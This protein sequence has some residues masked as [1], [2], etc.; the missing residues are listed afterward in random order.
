MR[1]KIT[2]RSVRNGSKR[3]ARSAPAVPAV[4]LI[5]GHDAE[6][7]RDPFVKA[8]ERWIG[9]LPQSSMRRMS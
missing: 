2:K 7:K 3:H 9:R 1:D 5:A 8:L 4:H 6:A